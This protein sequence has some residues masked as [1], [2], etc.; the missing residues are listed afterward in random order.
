VLDAHASAELRDRLLSELE[1]LRSADAMVA[2]AQD[3]LS[4]KNTLLATDAD[5]V[6]RAFRTRAEQVEH[7][8]HQQTIDQGA[9]IVPANDPTAAPQPEPKAAG[10][11]SSGGMD[12]A[13]SATEPPLRDFRLSPSEAMPTGGPESR[14]AGGPPT[15]PNLVRHSAHALPSR[16]PVVPRTPRLRDRRHLEFVTTQPCLVCGRH[17][18]EAHHLR[19]AQ[20]RALGRRVS[21]E[22]TVPLCRIHHDEIHRRGDEVAW[23][24][25]INIDPLPTAHRLWQHT[26]GLLPADATL[27]SNT[28][29]TPD[30][31]FDVSP[32]RNVRAESSFAAD[33][34]PSQK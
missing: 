10:A 27:S 26:R 29:G 34:G 12:A 25:S 20:P 21:D 8:Y 22:F 7:Q 4:L 14:H 13:G 30:P 18:C 24:A 3:S 17:P 28:P 33:L 16:R 32:N 9:P 6:E 2:W 23:W 5:A 11:D 31:G 1:G 19:F 15:A